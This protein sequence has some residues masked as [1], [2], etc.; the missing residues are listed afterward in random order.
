M[1]VVGLFSFY[2][3]NILQHI[4]SGWNVM[5]QHSDLISVVYFEIFYDC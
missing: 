3:T 4:V 5:I 1:Y 2:I